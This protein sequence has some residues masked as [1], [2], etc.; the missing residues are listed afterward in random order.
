MLFLGILGCAPNQARG[1]TR[2]RVEDASA[3]QAQGIS[4]GNVGIPAGADEG[5]EQ[6][7]DLSFLHDSPPPMEQAEEPPILPD[8][9]GLCEGLKRAN[10]TCCTVHR[11]HSRNSCT[12]ED[13]QYA[14]AQQQIWQDSLTSKAH[15]H[16]KFPGNYKAVVLK[17]FS[18]TLKDPYSAKYGRFSIP[19]KEHAIE[20]ASFQKAIFGWSTC[21]DVNAK[22]SFGAYAGNTTFWFLLVDGKIARSREVTSGDEIYSGRP[23]NCADGT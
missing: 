23:I 13:E 8:A 18:E 3:N 12:P 11:A 19:R 7:P 21:V 20:D 9:D 14:A 4:K 10:G 17:R 1:P 2:P 6:N 5:T 22:N 15:N 16:G